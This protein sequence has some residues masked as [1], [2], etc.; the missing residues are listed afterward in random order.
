MITANAYTIMKNNK[1]K[2]IINAEFDGRLGLAV[3]SYLLGQVG[4]D[5][6]KG[7]TDKE[8][9]SVKG[10][11]FMTDSFSQ[12]MVRCARRIAQECNLISDV[13]PY[14]ITEHGYLAGGITQERTAEILRDYIDN[15]LSAA[16][17]GYVRE[18]LTDCCGCD[19]EELVALELFDWLGFDKE[20]EDYE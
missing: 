5:N 16:D 12:A 17:P 3:I 10:N 8:I 14:I 13:I 20:D 19:E 2:E 7:I 9:E 15:D 18:T 4:M 11:A 1:V 6:A